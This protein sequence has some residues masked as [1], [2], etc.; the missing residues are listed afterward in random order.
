MYLVFLLYALFASTF[1]ISKTALNYAEPFFLIGTRMIAA[2]L[3]MLVYEW[4]RSGRKLA[5]SKT[6]LLQTALLGFVNIYVTNACEFYGLKH[7][8]SFKTCF[9]YSLS[10]FLSALF[11][12]FLLSEKM[13]RK[14]WIGFAVGFMGF[15]PIL[16]ISQEGDETIAHL[17]VISWPEI[18]VITAAVCSVYGW[19]LLGQAV[20]THG[21]SLFTVNGLSMLFGGILALGHS[22]TVE[23]WDPFPYS[24]FMPYLECTIALLVVSNLLAYNLYGYL[25]RSY[26]ATFMSFAGFL[27][28]LFTAL[29]GW[30]FLGEYVTLPFYISALI[31]FT[32]LYLFHQE[33]LKSGYLVQTTTS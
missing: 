21:L 4:F 7:L 14:K 6:V 16:A 11:S 2:G 15:L 10:P 33:E 26:T 9:I 18:S 1:T 8:T 19:I 31:V 23:T 27:T 28:P 25:L 24:A 12:Y 22:W 5:I 3:F 13:T 29:F 17:A 32:G 30:F 20:R